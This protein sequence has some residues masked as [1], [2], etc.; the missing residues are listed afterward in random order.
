MHAQMS[1]GSRRAFL[2]NCVIATST[3]FPA[4]SGSTSIGPRKNLYLSDKIPN[5]FS[6]TLLAQESR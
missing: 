5:A 2:A 1:F 4:F 3:N 6:I